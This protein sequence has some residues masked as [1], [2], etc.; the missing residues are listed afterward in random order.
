M[1]TKTASAL[2]ALV[3]WY[4]GG[5]EPNALPALIA[6]ARIASS[7]KGAP[8]S[9]GGENFERALHAA[10]CSARAALGPQWHL[11]PDASQ[12]INIPGSL[13][14]Y[15]TARGT[16]IKMPHDHRAPAARFWP[17]EVLPL[18]AEPVSPSVPAYLANASAR[19]DAIA[20]EMDERAE[21]FAAT[22]E[23]RKAERKAALGYAA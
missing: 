1:T 17:G 20:R 4:D 3:S 21:R 2:A 7:Q 22:A 13:A 9:S 16:H 18:K 19:M 23:A 8:K 14:T 6:S 12:W 5:A 15:K 11:V 10:K